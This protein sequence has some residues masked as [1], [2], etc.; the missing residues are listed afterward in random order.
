MKAADAGAA[1]VSHK[2][3][4]EREGFVGAAPLPALV[5]HRRDGTEGKIREQGEVGACTAFSLASTLD[6]ALSRSGG[7]PGS[8][9]VLHIWS[10]Y[11]DAFKEDAT[12]ANLDRPLAT[13]AQWPYDEKGACRWVAK[14]DCTDLCGDVKGA[15]CGSPDAEAQKHADESG[16]AKLA[17]VTKV[18]TTTDDLRAV[19][20]KGQDVWFGM[21]LDAPVFEKLK[22][23]DVVSPD[24][25]GRD[26][27][28]G[29]AMS[30]VGYRLQGDETFFLLKNS[31]GTSWGD[32]GY[33]W[34]HEATLVRN[35]DH[36]YVVEATPLGVTA[37]APSPSAIPSVLPTIPTTLPTTLPTLV[38][39]TPPKPGPSPSSTS[40]STPPPS[41]P[42][43]I[44]FPFTPIPSTTCPKGQVPDATSGKCG[45]ACADGSAPFGG[46]CAEKGSCPAGYVDLFGLCVISPADKSGL[47]DDG[48]AYD[49]GLGGCVYA[50][51]KG[52]LGCKELL[53][54]HVC[55]SPK[56]LASFGPRG[57]GCT[58]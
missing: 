50:I 35:I 26:S 40:T 38:P 53:C 36:A 45:K 46:K 39:T 4:D 34:M 41:W 19:V 47:A 10:R 8:V 3:L 25:D 29:H 33:A 51:P 12:A 55:P 49:C 13:E 22:G 42:F 14:K 54:L 56:F 44:P 43:P 9:A 28:D 2:A 57:L 52:A 16:V 6:H 17:S 58:E 24:F 20:A 30:I 48:V 23:K 5:D 1:I 11:A 21:S 37:P 7:K 32:Q 31:W 27:G 18:K 15:K